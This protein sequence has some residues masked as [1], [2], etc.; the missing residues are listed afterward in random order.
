[1][2]TYQVEITPAARQVVGLLDDEFTLGFYTFFEGFPEND[3]VLI[4]VIKH[5]PDV[6]INFHL[7][8]NVFVYANYSGHDDQDL[9][10]RFKRVIRRVAAIDHPIK[11]I[12]VRIS[13]EH[14]GDAQTQ[15]LSLAHCYPGMGERS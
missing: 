6:E 5:F 14:N 1:M 2:T 13:E 15:H 9:F 4:Y 3:P 10:I 11:D 7:R 12:I 8:D